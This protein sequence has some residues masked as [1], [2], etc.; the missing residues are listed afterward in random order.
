MKKAKLYAHEK[1]ID[2]LQTAIINDFFL[3]LFAFQIPGHSYNSNLSTG[4][5]KKINGDH[6]SWQSSFFF[7]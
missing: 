5:S 1:V 6:L 3:Q 4:S 7:P 2:D